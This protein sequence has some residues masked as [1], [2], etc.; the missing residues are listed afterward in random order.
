ME[1]K[2]WV[3]ER[4]RESGGISFKQ[5]LTNQLAPSDN[6]AL[7]ILPGYKGEFVS[8]WVLFC[9]QTKLSF[10]GKVQ[11]VKLTELY[12]SSKWDIVSTTIMADFGYP[13]SLVIRYSA[14]Y[15]PK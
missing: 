7:I 11:V 9:N 3:S 8:V 10:R 14:I 13:L 12:F 1:P 2:H 15:I 4:E 5:A 6:A